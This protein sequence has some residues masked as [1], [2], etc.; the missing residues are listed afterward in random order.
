MVEVGLDQRAEIADGDDDFCDAGGAQLV[1]D[2]LQDRPVADGHQRLGQDRRVGAQPHPLS[3]GQYH[4]LHDL[5]PAP[6]T[7]PA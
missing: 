7:V 4:R 6:L 2:D 1:Q 5:A 3:A